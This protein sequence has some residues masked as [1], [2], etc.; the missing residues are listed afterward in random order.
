MAL[1]CGAIW[2]HREKLQYRCTTTPSSRQL[3]N[4]F[5][6]I[7]LLYDFWCTQ[8]CS[9]R[10]IFG[11]QMEIVH[12]LIWT[13]ST[14]G[15]ESPRRGKPFDRFLEFLWAFICP[16]ILHEH[17]KFEVIHFRGYG[18]I[19]Q[20]L[21]IGQ[22]G[23]IPTP[24]ADWGE[25]LHSQAD[26]HASQPRQVSRESVQRVCLWVNLIPAACASRNP[27]GKYIQAIRYEELMSSAIR[28]RKLTCC[29]RLATST[30]VLPKPEH[31]MRT[32]P[33]ES[34][35]YGVPCAENLTQKL[36]MHQYA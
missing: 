5:L 6:K 11:L 21:R 13:I 4:F 28:T 24:C 10:A 20:K 33:A 31:S 26:P 12:I 7:Y 2:C 34:T 25:I 16:S 18:V 29:L 36:H 1:C 35:V 8:T 30:H 17:F 15:K 19:A 23:R 32:I 9:F 27:T 14:F 3:P 22:L